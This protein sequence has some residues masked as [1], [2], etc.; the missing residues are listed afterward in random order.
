MSAGKIT[1]FPLANVKLSSLAVSPGPIVWAM[2]NSPD[3]VG[4]FDPADGSFHVVTTTHAP[5]D[6]VLVANGSVWL[7]VSGDSP[8]TVVRRPLTLPP[9]APFK[10]VAGPFEQ[11]WLAMTLAHASD[12]SIWVALSK[13]PGTS[14]DAARLERIV[15]PPRRAARPGLAQ[16]KVS[17]DLPHGWNPFSVVPAGP[18]SV[19]VVSRTSNT[20]SVLGRVQLKSGALT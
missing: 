12:D 6:G 9:G 2:T 16:P 7:I 19:Y 20:T 13:N 17:I 15:G 18:G 14:A 5:S 11:G 10:Q 8:P 1:L 4:A 3:G